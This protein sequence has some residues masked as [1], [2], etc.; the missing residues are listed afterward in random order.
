MLFGITQSEKRISR[1]MK[2]GLKETGIVLFLDCCISMNSMK[3]GLKVKEISGKSVI[4]NHLS[5]KR[6]L[7]ESLY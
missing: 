3:R 6:G 4:V 5:M 1:S 2:R 7:K